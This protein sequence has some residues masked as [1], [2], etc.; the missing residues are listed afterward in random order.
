MSIDRDTLPYRPCVGIM[1]INPDWQVFVG[2]RIDQ[3][4]EAWQMPQGGIDE[5][6]SPRDAA[7]RELLEEIGTNCAEILDETENWLAYD[8]PDELLGR[9]WQGRYRGQKQKWFAMRFTGEDADIDLATAHPEFERWRWSPLAELP[10]M[11]V[12]F[13]RGIYQQVVATFRPL[14]PEDRQ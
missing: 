2:Q 14:F 3:Q 12:A 6:E 4:V 9:V 1:L 7:F 10:E 8:L 13:K 11:A 5:G